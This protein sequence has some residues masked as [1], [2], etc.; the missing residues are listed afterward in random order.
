MT[1]ILKL[2][3]TNK[4]KNLLKNKNNQDLIFSIVDIQEKSIKNFKFQFFNL[5][6]FITTE[7][8]HFF[9]LPHQ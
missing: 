2:L 5:L 1:N 4:N 7:V 9:H 8:M 6:I 3:T